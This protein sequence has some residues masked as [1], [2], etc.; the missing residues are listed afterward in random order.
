MCCLNLSQT[1]SQTFL[2]Y[3]TNMKKFIY[4]LPRIFSIL[5]IIFI[6]LFAL[7]AFLDPQWFL[8][9][10]IHLIPTFVLI[11][12]TSIAWKYERLGGAIFLL[13]G[14]SFLIITRFQ[15]PILFIPITLIG[16]GFLT[17]GYYS[18]N[19]DIFLD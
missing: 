3:N 16:I 13:I 4:W 18:K 6:S 8:S 9:L 19:N 7:D 11:G 12:A 15:G 10:V 17:S 2:R 1:T 5:F 14:L